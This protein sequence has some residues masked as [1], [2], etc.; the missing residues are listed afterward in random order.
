MQ[1][2]SLRDQILDRAGHVFDRD[3]R[4]DA[5][6][7]RRS[8]S[9]FAT[10]SESRRRPCVCS[11]ALGPPC[12]PSRVDVPAKLRGDRHAVAERRQCLAH[13]PFHFRAVG[14]GRIEELRRDRKPRGRN[15]HARPARRSRVE[16]PS[17]PGTSPTL[18]T[19]LPSCLPLTS[20]SVEWAP[21][22]AKAGVEDRCLSSGGDA[23]VAR[24]NDRRSGQ[25]GISVPR[26]CVYPFMFLSFR[27]WRNGAKPVSSSCR[28]IA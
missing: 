15:D 23:P 3:R 13:N 24:R 27:L 9:R 1:D 8:I 11:G 7:V 25:R 4:I 21:C 17:Y 22:C 20:R 2:L 18:E 12:G 6:L 14:F 10:A 28:M 19:R 16:P 5:V 26:L